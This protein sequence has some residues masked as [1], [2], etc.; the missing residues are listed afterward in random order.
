M[1]METTTCS[2]PHGKGFDSVIRRPDVVNKKI[3][4]SSRAGGTAICRGTHTFALFGDSARGN[5]S[6]AT[7]K[8]ATFLLLG[9]STLTKMGFQ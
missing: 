6:V 1:I 2:L 4:D 7:N 9:P 3:S 5:M 8:F